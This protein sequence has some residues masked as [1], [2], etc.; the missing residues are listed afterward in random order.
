MTSSNSTANSGREYTWQ[1]V[2][3]LRHFRLFRKAQSNS[4][5]RFQHGEISSYPASVMKTA[6]SANLLGWL[7]SFCKKVMKLPLLPSCF[8]R[9]TLRLQCLVILQRE[10][11]CACL[12]YVYSLKTEDVHPEGPATN[13]LW[14]TRE[15]PSICIRCCMLKLLRPVAWVSHGEIIMSFPLTKGP[16]NRLR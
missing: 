3:G 16:S 14:L 10:T 11:V 6:C 13:S 5:H 8:H 12:I 7:P 1:L 2:Q 9:F 4:F 15:E